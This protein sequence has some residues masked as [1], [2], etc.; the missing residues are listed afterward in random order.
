MK[1]KPL[2][3]LCVLLAIFI[4]FV[5]Q[6]GCGNKGNKK[7][8]AS[9]EIAL[10][11]FMN[12]ADMCTYDEDWPIFKEAAKETGIK[13]KSIPPNEN[14][15]SEQAFDTMLSSKRFPDII[16]GEFNSLNDIGKKG[17]LIP[18]E[19]LIDKYAPHISELFEKYPDFKKRATADDG[20]I[21]YLPGSISGLENSALPSTGWF[22]RQDW[23]D[24]LNLKQPETMQELVEVW[25]AFRN[26]DPNGN[27]QKDEIPFFARVEALNPLFALFGTQQSGYMPENGKV[28]FTPVTEKYKEAVKAI[29]SWYA[30]GLID[31]EIFTRGNSAREQLLGEDLGGSCHDWFSSTAAYSSKYA[32]KIPEIKFIPMAPPENIYGEKVEF[33]SRRAIHGYGWGISKDNEY[34]IQTMEYFDFWYTDKG[35]DLIS[36]GVEGEHYSVSNGK[37]ILNDNV[38][39]AEGGAPTFMRE[40]GQVEIGAIRDFDAEYQAMSEIAKKGFDLYLENGFCKPPT[41]FAEFTDAENVVKQKYSSDINTFANDQLRK[42]IMGV[43]DVDNTWDNYVQTINFMHLD[44]V[45]QIYQAAYERKNIY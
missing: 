5:F 38:L 3:S 25:R 19:D 17:T 8:T 45:T 15:S 27:G 34:P 16:H 41:E 37:K 14:P 6:T 36:Y 32:D 22:I 39:N 26:N 28:V 43:E 44:E 12:V 11:I 23:L 13:L 31:E 9:E 35:K 10:T 29:S 42:W 4:A 30:E 18:L 2:K 24:K 40:I 7:E 1:K 20:H 21:Y 33:S